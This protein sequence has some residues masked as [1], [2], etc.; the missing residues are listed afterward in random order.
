MPSGLFVFFV[1]FVLFRF[2]E[3]DLSWWRYCKAVEQRFG[4]AVAGD[5][6]GVELEVVTDVDEGV[7][8][9]GAVAHGH[10]GLLGRGELG[11]LVADFRHF[12]A[13]A[14]FGI[15]DALALAVAVEI[16]GPWCGIV[17]HA[18]ER[19]GAFIVLIVAAQVK[20][21]AVGFENGRESCT[22]FRTGRV[23]GAVA[24]DG[25]VLE[26]DEPAGVLLAGGFEVGVEPGK[27]LFGQ[28]LAG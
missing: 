3:M 16:G 17:G 18:C 1:V 20:V 24:I 6:E 2:L 13:G 25:F 9:S 28:I 7:V 26:D 8:V 14:D 5:A 4:S 12:A 27:L 11:E 10:E 23:A 22:I 15:D 21:Y 19:E